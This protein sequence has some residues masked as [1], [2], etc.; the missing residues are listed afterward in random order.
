MFFATGLRE[1]LSTCTAERK[2]DVC[3]RRERERDRE[4]ERESEREKE[5]ERELREGESGRRF[6]LGS[7]LR[8]RFRVQ[9]SGFTGPLPESLCLRRS[10]SWQQRELRA[11]RC[12]TKTSIHSIQSRT[13]KP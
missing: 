13:P 2:G 5:R 11:A 10:R 3:K 7:G 9:G 1:G 6:R 4:R 8:A 12:R